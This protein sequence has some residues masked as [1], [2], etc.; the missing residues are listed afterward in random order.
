VTSGPELIAGFMP[1]RRNK[2]GRNKPRVV[3]TMI[4]EK[5][6]GLF[7]NVNGVEI[8]VDLRGADFS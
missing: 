8:L 4:A 3:A 6:P 5:S 2:K 7:H 1:I